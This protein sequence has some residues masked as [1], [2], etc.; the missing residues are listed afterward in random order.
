MT[1]HWAK[2]PEKIK[3]DKRARFNFLMDK[4]IEN[5]SP[6]SA[7]D[8]GEETPAE[9]TS[10]T[11]TITIKDSEGAGLPD[12]PV[13]LSDSDEEFEDITEL[14]EDTDSNGVATFTD[15]PYYNHWALII[16]AGDYD[17]SEYDFANESL[18]D[19]YID[20]NADNKDFTYTI[21]PIGGGSE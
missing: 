10:G 16:E 11:V 20:I 7:D 15:V 12:V 14:Q 18:Q 2:A 6:S 8:E 13:T 4:I 21:L 9:E 1:D 5:A 19:L 17:T 3:T